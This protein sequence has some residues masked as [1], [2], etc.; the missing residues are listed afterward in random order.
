[1]LKANRLID[2][3]NEKGVAKP[4]KLIQDSET[5]LMDKPMNQLDLPD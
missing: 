3:G 5:W 4:S 1:L 2:V